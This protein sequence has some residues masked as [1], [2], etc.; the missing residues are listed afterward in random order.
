MDDTDTIDKGEI[1]HDEYETSLMC[2][3]K[4]NINNRNNFSASIILFRSKKNKV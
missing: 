3:R 1:N 4:C 2:P